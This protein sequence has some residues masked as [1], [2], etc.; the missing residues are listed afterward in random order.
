MWSVVQLGGFCPRRRSFILR[1]PQ[2][3]LL[4]TAALF[5]GVLCT[6]PACVAQQEPQPDIRDHI[7]FG[8][9]EPS[10][11]E[12]RQRIEDAKRRARDVARDRG[13]HPEHYLPVSEDAEVAASERV[14]RDETL[15]R[16]DIVTTKRGM[17]VFQGRSDRPRDAQDFAPIVPK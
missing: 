3:R 5:L 15:Q 12:W 16:G 1:P 14:L 4:L 17:F 7:G 13:L 6:P 11:D 2:Y 9:P 8:D 10:R